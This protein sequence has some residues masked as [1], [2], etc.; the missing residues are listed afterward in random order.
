MRARITSHHTICAP[1]L[2]EPLHL[3]T[4]TPRASPSAHLDSSSRT[5]AHPDSSGRMR[6]PTP[7]G[8]WHTPL[9]PS[10]HPDSSGCMTHCTFAP[11]SSGCTPAYPDSSGRQLCISCHPESSARLH[12]PTLSPLPRL[13]QLARAQ[14]RARSPESPACCPTR[15]DSDSKPAGC[16]FKKLRLR[17]D[18]AGNEGV[19]VMSVLSLMCGLYLAVKQVSTGILR[20]EQVHQ[21]H[22]AVLVV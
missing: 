20:A 16:N 13:W 10:A 6:S 1:R 18:T 4:S 19:G 7:R 17:S 21:D 22:E 2:L 14:T 3:C 11:D 8:A 15:T 5:Y 9:T 12:A